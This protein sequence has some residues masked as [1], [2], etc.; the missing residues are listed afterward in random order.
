[1]NESISL[2]EENLQFLEKISQQENMSCDEFLNELLER[3]Q[4]QPRPVGGWFKE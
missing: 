2:S 4:E 1:M 3:M